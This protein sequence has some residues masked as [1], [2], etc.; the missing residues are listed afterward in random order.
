MTQCILS[1]RR[2]LT[3]SL[4]FCPPGEKSESVKGRISDNHGAWRHGTGAVG[5]RDADERGSGDSQYNQSGVHS[6]PQSPTDQPRH[7][8]PPLSR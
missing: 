2:L 5:Q 7:V 8:Q 6:L 3:P 4:L 1:Y